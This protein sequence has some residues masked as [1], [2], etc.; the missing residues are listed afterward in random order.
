MT[1]RHSL[2][3]LALAASLLLP[4]ALLAGA[5]GR[6]AGDGTGEAA[7][8]TPAAAASPT[9]GVAYEPAYPTDVSAEGLSAQDVSQQ[10]IPHR[11]DGGEEHTHG[12]GEDAAESDDHGHPH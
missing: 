3:R 7:A 10:E 5:C 9:A 11:H 4:A 1:S 12:E 6:D 2:R 8:E